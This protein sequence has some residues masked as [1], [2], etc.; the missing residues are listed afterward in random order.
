[1]YKTF[2]DEAPARIKNKQAGHHRADYH[3]T[4]IRNQ[5]TEAALKQ[6]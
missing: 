4:Y 2:D 6:A 1:M 3:I 5:S